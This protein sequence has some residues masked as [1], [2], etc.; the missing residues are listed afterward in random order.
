M[1]MQPQARIAGTLLHWGNSRPR[2]NLLHRNPNTLLLTQIHLGRVLGWVLGAQGNI[3][4]ILE[5]R[6]LYSR[7][8]HVD[9]NYEP[10][11]NYRWGL[12]RD[13]IRETLVIRRLCNQDSHEGRN[14]EPNHNRMLPTLR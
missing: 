7:D 8:I 11:R 2:R 13:S 3:P 1:R 14:C 9:R 5:S 12:E 6:H 10:S 4:E